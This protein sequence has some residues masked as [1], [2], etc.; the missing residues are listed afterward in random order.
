MVRLSWREK[1]RWAVVAA[2]HEVTLSE[3]VRTAVREHVGRR[4][5]VAPTREASA[6]DFSG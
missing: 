6:A 4:Q 5:R 1:L 2:N 3:L